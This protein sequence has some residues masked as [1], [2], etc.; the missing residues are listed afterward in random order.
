M[1]IITFIRIV[2]FG[3]MMGSL[4]PA[5]TAYAVGT[6][7][8]ALRE[9]ELIAVPQFGRSGF[10]QGLLPGEHR[11]GETFHDLRLR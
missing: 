7:A 4:F 6:G 3:A 11:V 1:R 9:G 5:D 10:G 2:C 8:S